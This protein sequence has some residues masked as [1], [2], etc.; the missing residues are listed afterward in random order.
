MSEAKA[1]VNMAT[2][3][4]YPRFMNL[5]MLGF[6]HGPSYMYKYIICQGIVLMT[7]IYVWV[8]INNGKIFNF[9][10]LKIKL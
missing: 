7:F 9:V 8:K 2:Y 10:I 5:W 6:T 3:R 1:N 4:N